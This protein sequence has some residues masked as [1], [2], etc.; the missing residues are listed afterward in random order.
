MC[1]RS[2]IQLQRERFYLYMYERTIY[3]VTDA[4]CQYSGTV[5]MSI[6]Q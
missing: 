1:Q 4:D 3:F 2:T 5:E 6:E